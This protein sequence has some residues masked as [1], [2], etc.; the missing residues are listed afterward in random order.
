MLVRL[1]ANAAG[2][3]KAIAAAEA[4]V[5]CA[6]DSL[7]KEE[8]EADVAARVAAETEEASLAAQAEISAQQVEAEIEIEH[9]SPVK[10]DSPDPDESE[11]EVTMSDFQ[12]MMATKM[13]GC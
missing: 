8:H 13:L 11:E 7:A 4:K 1:Q 12:K 9:S 2:D 3:D 5:E 6:R 10:S